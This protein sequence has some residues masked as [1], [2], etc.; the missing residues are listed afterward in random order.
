MSTTIKQCANC[1]NSN[2]EHNYQ[3]AQYGKFNRVINE[4]EKGGKCTVCGSQTKVQK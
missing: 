3:D 4:S 2:I 1:A